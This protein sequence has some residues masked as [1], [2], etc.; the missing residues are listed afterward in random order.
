MAEAAPSKNRV[1]LFWRVVHVAIVANLLAEI[2][3]AGWMVFFVLVPPGSG[4]APLG[5]AALALPHDLMMT[6]RLYALEAW[7]AVAGLSV[8]LGVTEIAPR[9]W[10]R[11]R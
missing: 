2:A 4:F 7:V 3:Y 9:F 1:P 6:R 10:K 5:R 11:P 8:Y